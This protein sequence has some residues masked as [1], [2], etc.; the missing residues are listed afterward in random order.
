MTVA[1][2]LAVGLTGSAR[3]TPVP[4]AVPAAAK[5]TD[6]TARH[7][8][9]LV[10]GDRVI[11]DAKGRVVGMERAKGRERVPVQMRRSDG[12][13]LVIP[14]DV[15]QMIASG[16]LD[17]RLFDITELDKAANRRNQGDGVKVIV[18]YKGAA[19]TAKSGVRDTGTLRHAFGTLNLDTVQTSSGKAPGLWHALTHEDALSPGISHV[20][21]D[22]VRT[23]S[24]DKSVPQIGAP[25]AWARG[26]NGK[27]VK[28][29]VLDTGIDTSHPDLKDQVIAA[30]NFSTATTTDDHQGHGTH[31][32]STIA[33][34]GAKSAGK[35]KGVAPG[36]K[37]L[38]GKVLNDQ[39]EGDDSGIIAGMEW[40]AAQGAGHRQPQPG[41]RRHS[42]HRPDGSHGQPAVRG[43]GRPLRHRRGQRGRTGRAD[44]RLP[45]SAA[46][47]LTV[48][49]VDG[50]DRLADFVQPQARP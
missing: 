40:A 25:A 42:G 39:G 45:G 10:T 30:K 41:R 19:S 33:G 5:S 4:T 3:A 17:Q 13:T 28:V 47:A 7:R 35:Y 31:V 11:V 16:R 24:L 23:M 12:H 44:R 48:G 15:A 18:G 29:A 8:I 9:T 37:L 6:N 27:G 22:G 38:S 26:Y 20:W 46:D 2:A 49:A 36:A 21:L 32:A 1:A 43:E 34:T 14:T 50:N